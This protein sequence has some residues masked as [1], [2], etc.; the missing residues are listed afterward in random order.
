VET[1]CLFSLKQGCRG[2]KK[3][4][5]ALIS[6]RLPMLEYQVSSVIDAES[7]KEAQRKI[8]MRIGTILVLPAS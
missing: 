2:C 5:K 8:H 6:T 1:Y 7:F 3:D 4:L